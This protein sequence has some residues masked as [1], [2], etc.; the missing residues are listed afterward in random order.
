MNTRDY[1]A[2]QALDTV[3]LAGNDHRDP[4]K[5]AAYAYDY[6]D[7]MMEERAKRKK[8]RENARRT[9]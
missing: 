8:E 9:G 4:S 5:A 6:A 7:A 2:G 3:T 1:F